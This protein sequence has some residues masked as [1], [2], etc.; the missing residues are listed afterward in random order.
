MTATAET[1]RCV[2]TVA[3]R[4]LVLGAMAQGGA[5][6]LTEGRAWTIALRNA[7]DCQSSG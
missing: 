4:D 2:Y 7:L 5:G 3:S 6:E 1:Q